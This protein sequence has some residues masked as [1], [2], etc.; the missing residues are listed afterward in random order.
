LAHDPLYRAEPLQRAGNLFDW[1]ASGKLKFRLEKILPLSE[2]V[3][4]HRLLE[5][6]KTT[7][8]I[9]LVP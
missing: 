6:R 2:T 1:T 5:S 3:E 7:A 8:Q 9:V 4:A